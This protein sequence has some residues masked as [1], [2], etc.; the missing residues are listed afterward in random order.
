MKKIFISL[1]IGFF[2]A[3]IQAQNS[4]MSIGLQGGVG[5]THSYAIIPEPIFFGVCPSVAFLAGIDL[6]YD[7]GKNF[8]LETDLSFERKGHKIPGEK[9]VSISTLDK[10]DLNYCT[11]GFLLRKAFQC[12]RMYWFINAGP[13]AAYLGSMFIRHFE[14]PGKESVWKMDFTSDYTRFDAGVTTGIGAG[15]RVAEKVKLSFEVKNNLGLM[16]I[17]G[18]PE[19]GWSTKTYSAVF[20]TGVSCSMNEKTKRKTIEH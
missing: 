16:N 15:F 18:Y 8:S 6:Q 2:I 3:R 1:L 17:C 20:L 4:K 7:L 11:I 12:K 10:Y 14:Y 13:F 9:W 5:Y 19:N